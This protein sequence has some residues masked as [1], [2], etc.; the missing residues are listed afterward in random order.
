MKRKIIVL[1]IALCLALTALAGATLAYFTD[2]EH[3]DNTF[4]MK[5]IDITLE[6]DFE[7]GSELFPGLDINKDVR[8]TNEDHSS[9]AYV[10][11]HIAVPALLDNNKMLCLAAPE[12]ST[13]DGQWSRAENAYTATV[14]GIE[15]NVYVVTYMTALASCE[16]TETDALDRV[17]LDST[18]DAE[19]DAEA[20]NW[21]L[22]AAD[23]TKVDPADVT[24]D[25]NIMHVLVFAEGVQT[26]T[27][28]D[29][30][31]A[32]NTAFGDPTD[33]GYTAPWNR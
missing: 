14:D 3:A 6:E 16:T 24:D 4:T 25:N 27:F 12:G 8:V 28:D 17:Y 22:V 31:T 5:G 1:A 13:E 7:Q 18:V 2:E 23:G 20:E 11:V 9:D 15:Y 19:Y 29:A 30:E 26:A 33:D 21:V 32:L 10:R